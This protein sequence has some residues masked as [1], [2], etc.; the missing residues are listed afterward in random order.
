[1][2]ALN[3]SGAD[4]SLQARLID[5]VNKNL[6]QYGGGQESGKSEEELVTLK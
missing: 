2:A 1:M 3:M 4:R 5:A 6:D